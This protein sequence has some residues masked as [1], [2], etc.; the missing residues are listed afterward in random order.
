MTSVTL[1]HFRGNSTTDIVF[2]INLINTCFF[3]LREIPV[4]L[5]WGPYVTRVINS[6]KRCGVATE[7]S[8]VPG[9]RGLEE[10]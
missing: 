10:G 7:P 2:F 8:E 6:L 1:P 3:P 5:L 4:K 9:Q